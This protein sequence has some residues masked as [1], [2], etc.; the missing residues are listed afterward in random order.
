MSNTITVFGKRLNCKHKTGWFKTV[1]I[2]K[3][4]FEVSAKY[5]LCLDCEDLIPIDEYNNESPTRCLTERTY[6][7]AMQE[8]ADQQTESLKAELSEL[9][10]RHKR[11]VMDAY[12]K[13]HYDG[14]DTSYWGGK[15]NHLNDKAEQYYKQKFESND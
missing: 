9:K 11:D 4:W 6:E 15:V 13:G 2:K 8:Y 3:W 1:I 10:E 12:S 14:C 7:K 5:F